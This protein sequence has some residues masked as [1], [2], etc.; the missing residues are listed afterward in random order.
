[1]TTAQTAPVP[2]L[3]PERSDAVDVFDI[4]DS[5]AESIVDSIPAVPARQ[6]SQFQGVA[7]MCSALCVL[8]RGASL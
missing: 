4:V 3:L 6:I 2:S 8:S 7:R 5:I 1:M